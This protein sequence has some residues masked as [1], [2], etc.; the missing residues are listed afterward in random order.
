MSP[1]LFKHNFE[2]LVKNGLL[3]LPL[4]FL[5]KHIKMSVI[6]YYCIIYNAKLQ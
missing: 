5:S 6:K 2:G 4:D 3:N 1:E